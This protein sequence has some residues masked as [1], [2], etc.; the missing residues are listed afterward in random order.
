MAS[1]CSDRTSASSSYSSTPSSSSTLSSS[2][3]PSFS[4]SSF[5]TP[6]S[7]LST[8]KR[9]ASISTALHQFN[10]CS[11]RYP[12]Q[13]ACELEV[14]RRTTSN[15]ST[16]HFDII[17]YLNIE[18]ISQYR[19]FF[20]RFHRKRNALREQQGVREIPDISLDR[21]WEQGRPYP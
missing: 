10:S 3:T 4:S 18:R 20:K 1:Q 17:S 6:L 13:L 16:I 11:V 12:Q 19:L 5:S 21:S 9:D 14:G 7:C 2:S 15:K 8:A